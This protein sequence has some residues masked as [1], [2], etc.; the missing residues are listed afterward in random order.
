MVGGQDELVFDGDSIVVD[1]AG[2]LLARGP[3]F[4]EALIVT[5]VEVRRGRA[6]WRS[7]IRQPMPA[8]APR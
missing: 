7:A 6:A 8:T 3:Q 5:D 2:T 4:E 1:A